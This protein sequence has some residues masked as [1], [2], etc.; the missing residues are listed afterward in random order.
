MSWLPYVLARL[1]SKFHDWYSVKSA[2]ENR[3]RICYIKLY[4]M[5]TEWSVAVCKHVQFK[6]Q[7]LKF[8]VPSDIFRIL[9]QTNILNSFHS[10]YILIFKNIFINCVKV[11]FFSWFCSCRKNHL[12]GLDV[13]GRIILK[14]FLKNRMG[15]F[16]L[17]LC[18][19]G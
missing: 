18:V 4:F 11:I 16:G 1:Y 19:S 3:R 10:K 6:Y 13:A 12:E 9:H 15:W 2:A 5:Y 17:D 14:W 8:L 7:R